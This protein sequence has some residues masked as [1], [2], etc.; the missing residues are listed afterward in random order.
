MILLNDESAGV[1]LVNSN[2]VSPHCAELAD[3]RETTQHAFSAK[4]MASAA[5]SVLQSLLG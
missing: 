5:A 4:S 2:T 3:D 1:Q